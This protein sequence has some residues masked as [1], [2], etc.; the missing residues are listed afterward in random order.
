M[1]AGRAW[2]ALI[3]RD[4]ALR[5]VGT[6]TKAKAAIRYLDRQWR[7]G[8]A[9]VFCRRSGRQWIRR[10]GTWTAQE[11]VDLTSL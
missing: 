11:N 8:P 5:R 7:R 10:K 1:T 9:A 4:G 2:V 3:K 6:F